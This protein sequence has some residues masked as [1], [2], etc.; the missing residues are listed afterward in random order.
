MF[1]ASDDDN[2]GT[3][4]EAEFQKLMVV[5]CGQ[6]FSRVLLYLALLLAISPFCANVIVLGLAY[7]L[8]D[9]PWFIA[10]F[11]LVQ[12]PVAKIPWLDAM[13]DW[14]TLAEGR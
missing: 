3:I 11:H 1:D 7:V 5:C 10:L 12:D 13:F 14:D 4:D 2:S 6:I 8:S 9:K